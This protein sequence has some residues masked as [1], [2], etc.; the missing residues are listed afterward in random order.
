MQCLV[1]EGCNYGTTVGTSGLRGR[2][3]TPKKIR[4]SFLQNIGEHLIDYLYV[5][6]QPTKVI[7]QYQI[8][9]IQLFTFTLYHLPNTVGDN[10][11]GF[12]M[13]L[14]INILLEVGYYY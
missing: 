9:V 13:L 10:I 6:S 11:L 12:K 7:V 1:P 14:C 8:L 4:G 3:S 5:V 2:I